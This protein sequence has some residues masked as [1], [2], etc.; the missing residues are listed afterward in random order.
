MSKLDDAFGTDKFK[1]LKYNPINVDLSNFRKVINTMKP[2]LTSKDEL[3]VMPTEALKSGYGLPKNH[4]IRI[5]LRP[6]VSSLN[7]ICSGAESYLHN[8]IAP[9]VAQCSFSIKSTKI[10]KEKFTE[11]Q[12]FDSENYEVISYDCIQ[13]YL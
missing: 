1:K 11:I 3:K 9:I 2:H 6:I 10:F 5:P 4:K 12:N 7:S 13:L 8:L